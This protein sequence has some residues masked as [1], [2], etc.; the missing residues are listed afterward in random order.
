MEMQIQDLVSAIRKDGIEEAEK[1][2]AQILEQARAEAER[3]VGDARA[4]AKKI[5]EETEAKLEREKAGTLSAVRQASRDIVLSLKNELNGIFTSILASKA[6]SSLGPQ[7]IA[8]I[9]IAAIGN[10]D[11]AKY[12]LQISTLRA[13][14]KASLARQIKDGLQLRSVGGVDG[15]RLASKDGSGF[16]GF[17]DEEVAAILKPYVGNLEI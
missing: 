2:K 6:G 14:L 5:E 12:E 1:Q 11:P 15:F 13:E 8:E 3:I 4:Q 16:Y 7:E 9:V 17:S 10:Q